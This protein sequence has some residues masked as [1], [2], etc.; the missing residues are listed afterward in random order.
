MRTITFGGV[1]FLVGVDWHS[2]DPNASL[3]TEVR[4]IR[5]SKKK[6]ADAANTLPTN[7]NNKKTFTHGIVMK[8]RHGMTLGVFPSGIKRTAAPVAL[9][10]LALANQQYQANMGASS[11]PLTVTSGAGATPL[12]WIV[13]EKIDNLQIEG[14]DAFWLGAII[15]GLPYAASDEILSL[16]DCIDSLQDLLRSSGGGFTVFST[17]PLIQSVVDNMPLQAQGIHSLTTDIKYDIKIKS[18]SGIPSWT[19]PL[20]GFILLL[21][22]GYFGYTKYQA[23]R[24]IA[25]AQQ[26]ASQNQKELL[27]KQKAAQSAYIQSVKQTIVSGLHDASNEINQALKQ[28]NPYTAVEGM[29]DLIGTLPRTI[30]GWTVNDTQCNFQDGHPS[31]NLSVT[32]GKGSDRMLKEQF[33]KAQITDDNATIP[34]EDKDVNVINNNID[35][36]K[37]I[38]GQYFNEDFK[39]DIQAFHNAG[40]GF[41]IGAGQ[42]IVK[43]I[44]LPQKPVLVMAKVPTSLG[45]DPNANKP[46]TVT[47]NIGISTGTLTV[48]SG[49][50]NTIQSLRDIMA[51]M[52]IKG[53]IPSAVSYNKGVWTLTAS[54]Y[55]RT[56]SKPTIP[57]VKLDD[58]TVVEVKLPD[59]PWV[60]TLYSSNVNDMEQNG[61]SP[62]SLLAPNPNTLNNA[63]NV[64]NQ[65]PQNPQDAN[66]LNL[67]SPQQ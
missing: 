36:S 52:N 45:G 47:S 23:S 60:H 28:S 19:L 42:N 41:Q 58:G 64:R 44:T 65:Q 43:S 2:L 13:I 32:R 25:V 7:K 11:G 56:A 8:Y 61:V 9:A 50:K 14:E 12:N 20:F 22:L 10:W 5:Q 34:F 62:S 15:D 24:A 48:S 55:V 63:P 31:C 37:I 39:S 66:P 53:I 6:E 16:H 38:S 51:V 27:E 35:G 40:M 54:Y 33:P 1:P 30:P 4:K 49:T 3:S 57:T 21:M 67:P 46:Q 18:L 29:A 26:A 17:D 59:E